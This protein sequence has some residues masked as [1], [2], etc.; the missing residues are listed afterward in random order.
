MQDLIAMQESNPR[1]RCR[2]FD[3]NL[4]LINMRKKPP[5]RI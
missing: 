5:L 3:C 1:H 2:G 4:R